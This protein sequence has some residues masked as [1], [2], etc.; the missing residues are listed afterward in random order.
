MSI[1][2]LT[3]VVEKLEEQEWKANP[4]AFGSQQ[5]MTTGCSL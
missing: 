2:K 5:T 4:V 1:W 3:K